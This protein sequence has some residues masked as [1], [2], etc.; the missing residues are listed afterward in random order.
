MTP[1]FQYTPNAVTLHPVVNGLS[2]SVRNF[3]PQAQEAAR[4]FPMRLPLALAQRIS[5]GEVDDPLA[6]EFL[7]NAA[8]L[9]AFPGWETDPLQE[10]AVEPIPGLLQKYAG[11]VLLKVT[12]GCAVHC[13]FCF[14]RHASGAGIPRTLREWE[15]AMT[16]IGA[17]H[18]LREV[19]LSGGDPL[20]LSDRRLSAL[21]RRLAGIPHLTRLRVHTRMPVVAPERVTPALTHWLRATRLTPV[22]VI[23]VNHPA[24]LDPAALAAMARLTDAGIPLLSQ[25]VLLRGVNDDSAILAALFERLADARVIPYYLHLPDPVAGTAH[26][27]VEEEVASGIIRELWATLPGYAVPRLAREVPGDLGKRLV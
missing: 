15:P 8:E 16:L 24:E 20:T 1:L 4:R 23:H 17:D 3:S 25:S 14:R 2:E 21:A 11:R 13:R 27:R 26:F 5:W 6:R 19:I 10:A 7:P 12:M 18:G 9:E 22:M